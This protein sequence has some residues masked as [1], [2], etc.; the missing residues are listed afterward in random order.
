MLLLKIEKFQKMSEEHHIF[1]PRLTIVNHFDDI[2]NK[3]DIQTET[4]LENHFK[5]YESLREERRNEINEIREKQIEKIKEIQQINLNTL[6]AQSEAK[7]EQKWSQI[8][9]DVSL[10]MS[11]KIDKIK[12]DLIYFDCVL[13][14]RPSMIEKKFNLWITSWFYKQKNLEF[15]K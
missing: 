3:I 2:I 14:D 13:L 5:E 12:E 15:L 9:N 4:L 11:Q 6:L 10:Q 8:I 1:N 7:N